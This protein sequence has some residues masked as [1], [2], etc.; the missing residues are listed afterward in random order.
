MLPFEL[1]PVGTIST[2]ETLVNE[3]VNTPTDMVNTSAPIAVLNVRLLKV[4][5]V[6]VDILAA[7]GNGTGPPT[8]SM[9]GIVLVVVAAEML[10]VFTV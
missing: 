9:L 7:F 6:P 5:G 2:E 3:N 10:P 4:T 8:A 1:G